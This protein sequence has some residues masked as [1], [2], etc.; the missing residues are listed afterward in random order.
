MNISIGKNHPEE[1][2][3]IVEIPKESHNKY[4][5]DE[6]LG[7][8]KLDRVLHSPLHYPADYGLIPE[9]RAEDG[10]HLD[11]LIIG[12]NPTF[13]G[14]LVEARPIGVMRMIDDG[15]KDFKILA[16]QVNNPRLSEMK[17]LEDIKKLNPHF[18]KEV[19]HFFEAYKHLE[20]KEVE[21][22]DWGDRKEALEE[23]RKTHEAYK[24]KE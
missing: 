5:Y 4:E 21:I 12:S 6:E 14:C 11:I 18:L 20:N 15:E 17:E 16:V 22:K 24:N 7:V 3:A 19:A 2:N 8:F 23:I 13:P 1:V 10:D 9:T